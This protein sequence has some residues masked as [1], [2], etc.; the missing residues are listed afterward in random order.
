MTARRCALMLIF[1]FGA[2]TSPRIGAATAFA[3]VVHALTRRA[4][5]ALKN[6]ARTDEL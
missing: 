4:Y 1:P 2:L 5:K 3:L 6:G